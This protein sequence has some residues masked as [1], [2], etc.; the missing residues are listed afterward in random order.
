[1]W[2][3]LHSAIEISTIQIKSIGKGAAEKSRGEINKPQTASL[4]SIG[5]DTL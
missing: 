5:M 1:M 3:I 4:H 2:L